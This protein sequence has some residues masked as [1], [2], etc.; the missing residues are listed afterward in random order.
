MF[1][2]L[3]FASCYQTFYAS[4]DYEKAMSNYAYNYD[5]SK[6]VNK[7]TNEPYL[8]LVTIQDRLFS[9]RNYVD[10]Y[11]FNECLI[12][13]KL[14]NQNELEFCLSKYKIKSAILN[15]D[16]KYI[17]DGKQYSFFS[18]AFECNNFDVFIGSRNIF[19]SY[20]KEISLCNLNKKDLF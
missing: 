19:S 4:I 12:N 3:L 1:S 5:L 14:K 16:G 13:N 17:I 8:N 20:R 2:I 10:V 9:D 6:I 18:N 7:K 15:K 11:S